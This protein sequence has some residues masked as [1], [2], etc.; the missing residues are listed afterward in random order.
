MSMMFQKL[1]PIEDRRLTRAAKGQTCI[2]CGTNDGTVCACHYN[3][4]RAYSYGKGR[5]VKCGDIFVADF[6]RACDDL[7]SEANYHRWDGGSQSV[8]R[9]EEFQHWVLKTIERR[10]RD[11]VLTTGRKT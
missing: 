8:E 1:P 5:G 10:V 9:S 6:C 2:R 11:G 4:F 7:F 3:G